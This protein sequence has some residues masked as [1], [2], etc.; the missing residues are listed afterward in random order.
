[1][2]EKS[3]IEKYINEVPAIPK[4]ILSVAKSLDEQD[5]A[6]AATLASSDLALINYMKNIVNKPIFGFRDELKDPK[7]IFGAL[8]LQR[9]RQILYSYYVSLLLPKNWKVFKLNNNQFADI[10]AS[11]LLEWQK[12]LNHIKNNSLELQQAI[13]LVPS[14]ISIC[15]SVFE[16]D[17]EIVNILKNQKSIS[18]DKILLKTTNL[19]FFDI[20]SMVAEKWEMPEKIINFLKSL[21]ASKDDISVYLKLLIAYILSKPQ[22]NESGLSDFFEFDIECEDEQMETFYKA[23]KG[24]DIETDN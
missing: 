8:G 4:I 14:A 18:Y 13:T 1:M 17:I 16:K 24:S 20:V 6:K 9:A 3:D 19:S 15:E 10:Q 2:F 11:F 7:Q 12:I 21:N 23:I 22:Y 5:L